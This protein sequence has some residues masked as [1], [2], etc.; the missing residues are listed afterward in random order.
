MLSIEI[1]YFRGWL[2]ICLENY[3]WL[4]LLIILLEFLDNFWTG[5]K[6]LFLFWDMSFRVSHI[7]RENNF[8][9]I[10][11]LAMKPLFLLCFSYLIQFIWE[12][13]FHNKFS[14]LNYRFRWYNIFFCFCTLLFF[15]RY[16]FIRLSLVN[17]IF[18]EVV[19]Y[20]FK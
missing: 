11:K 16:N 9:Q 1:I 19:T 3:L 18:N 13:F 17:N 10:I 6:I 14:F 12:D 15:L 5:G 2:N 4:S 8:V 20:R 7:Y